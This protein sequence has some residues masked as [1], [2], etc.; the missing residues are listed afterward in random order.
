M[1]HE[2]YG[3]YSEIFSVTSFTEL[4]RQGQDTQRWNMLHPESTPRRSHV[5]DMLPGENPVIAASDFQKA[6]ADQIRSQITAPYHVLGTDGFGRSDSR[7]A[8]REF[9]E[10]DRRFIVLAALKGLCDCGILPAET[11]EQARSDL[12]IDPEKANPR[13]S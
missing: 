5:A 8:L 1:L 4:A 9:F 3:V 7:A 6:V 2:R 11:V 13:V 10:V 12:D